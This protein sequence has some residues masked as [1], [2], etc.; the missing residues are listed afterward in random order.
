MRIHDENARSKV[1]SVP[2]PTVTRKINSLRSLESA[3]DPSNRRE[4]VNLPQGM[5]TL[6]HPQ[7][8][9]THVISLRPGQSLVFYTDGLNEAVDA[10]GAPF[11][12]KINPILRK[13]RFGHP[14]AIANA[15]MDGYQKHISGSDV[16]QDD[17]RLRV[18]TF[19][20]G[21]KGTPNVR[22]FP[23]ARYVVPRAN[24]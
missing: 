6:D 14:D 16:T 19:L 21:N 11:E 18:I 24:P 4:P 2:K 8:L 12:P 1:K 3:P 13:I 15:L 17:L 23:Y 7:R 5:F 20:S 10:Q 9:K 22:G